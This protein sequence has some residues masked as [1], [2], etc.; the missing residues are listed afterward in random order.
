MDIRAILV[1]ALFIAACGSSLRHETK[2]PTPPG[3][4]QELR[5]V[6]PEEIEKYSY[7][8][9]IDSFAQE[10]G[11]SKLRQTMLPNN[12]L[13]IRVQVGFGLY[14]VDALLLKR[15]AGEWRA[16]HYRGMICTLGNRGK[17]ALAAPKSGWD[18]AW[19]RL[20]EAGILSLSGVKDSGIKDG[21]SYIVETNLNR[22][23]LVYAFGNPD[24]LK[25]REGKQMVAIGDVIADEF[26][27]E[28]FKVNYMCK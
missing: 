26:G 6:I 13:E 27:L 22:T 16:A 18:A 10:N 4:K 21:T 11:L 14:G 5:V 7:I 20:K 8:Q 28:T 2:P 3:A 23:Y 19:Q 17:V 1:F 12:D 15:T 9:S 24:H 25:D